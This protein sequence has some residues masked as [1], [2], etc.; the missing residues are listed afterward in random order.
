MQPAEEGHADDKMPWRPCIQP[1]GQA[2]PVSMAC[3]NDAVEFCMHV[4]ACLVAVCVHMARGQMLSS[5]FNIWEK[6]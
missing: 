2:W 4:Q 5:C 3:N 6:K 1:K